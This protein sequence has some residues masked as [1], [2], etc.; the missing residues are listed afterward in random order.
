MSADILQTVIYN[1]P[2][3]AKQTTERVIYLSTI[4]QIKKRTKM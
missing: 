4:K 1:S 3:L 2:K